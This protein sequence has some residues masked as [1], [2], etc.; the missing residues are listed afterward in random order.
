M[1]TSAAIDV[2]KV[3]V[4]YIDWLS[5]NGR[6]FTRQNQNFVNS[7]EWIK[8]DSTVTVDAILQ[9]WLTCDAS[10]PSA[11]RLLLELHKCGVMLRIDGGAPWTFVVN[12]FF[13]HG[14]G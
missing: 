8:L 13:C 12:Q 2:E 11:Y 14:D 3:R 5:T 9:A 6:R 10:K 1:N 4:R 7:L